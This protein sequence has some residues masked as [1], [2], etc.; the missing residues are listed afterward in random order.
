M[1]RL[2]RLLGIMVVLAIGVPNAL[3]YAAFFC[4]E[5]IS[6][7]AKT[8]LMAIFDDHKDHSIWAFL[9][10]ETNSYGGVDII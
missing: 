8:M 10:G 7:V 3:F 4:P 5:P 9:R 6:G 2:L 1:K